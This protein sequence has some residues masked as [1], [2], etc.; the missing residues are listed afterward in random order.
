MID[1]FKRLNHT[2]RAG[3]FLAFLVLLVGVSVAASP[4][5]SAIRVSI[6]C[7]TESGNCVEGWNGTDITLYSGAGSTQVFQAD[8]A[9]GDV[10]LEGTLNI[11]DNAYTSVGA[12][13]LDP[14][15]SVYL[16]SPVTVLTLT[17]A[18]T[19][20]VA[21]DFVLLM[22]QVATDTTIVDTGATVGGGTRTLGSDGD[23][24]LLMY[25]G[26]KWVEVSFADNS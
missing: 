20:S 1:Y 16:L 22:S 13:T 4:V 17:L 2:A 9:L 19:T 11:G 25:D 8:G 26:A 5:A 6:L 10:T 12:Q 15:N 3:V 23:N 24:I 18:T 21:G 14:V 7:A